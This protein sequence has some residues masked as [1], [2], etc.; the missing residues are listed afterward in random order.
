KK[1]SIL[2][3]RHFLPAFIRSASGAGI[4]PQDCGQ[5]DRTC[6]ATRSTPAAQTR[7][8]QAGG[9]SEKLEEQRRRTQ[10]RLPSD[11]RLAKRRLT[12]ERPCGQIAAAR[13][14]CPGLLP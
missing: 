10:S 6:S 14:F 13:S 7:N 11:C 1:W 5:F 12:G 2:Y 9:E 4:C 8:D 3:H